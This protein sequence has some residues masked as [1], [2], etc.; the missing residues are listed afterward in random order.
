MR[1]AAASTVAVLLLAASG[2]GSDPPAP[3]KPAQPISLG[4]PRGALAPSHPSTGLPEGHPP[5]G[6]PEGHPP[7]DAP[8]AARPPVPPPVPEGGIAAD[9]FSAPEGW[10]TEKPSGSMRLLQFRLPRA[11]GDPADGEVVVF[12]RAM[13][14]RQS[15]ID[16]WRGQFAPVAKDA[17]RLEEIAAGEKGKVHLLDITGKYS[18]GMAPAAGAPAPPSWD[19]QTRM[20][21]AVVEVPAGTYYVKATGPAATMGKWES[22]VRAFI[23]D[24]AKK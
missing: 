20:L 22:T 18:G 1:V 9:R 16:R 6:L 11:D 13:G 7:V 5:T 10:Q 12:G 4:D 14:D 19:G 15:N 3:A 17:D 21:A 2:C 24:S 23:V 8:P